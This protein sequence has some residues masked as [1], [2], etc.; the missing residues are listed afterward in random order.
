[1]TRLALFLISAWL[2]L[3]PSPRAHAGDDPGVVFTLLLNRPQTQTLRVVMEIPQLT[4]TEAAVSMPAWRPGR[5]VI[6][7]PAS[8]VRTFAAF[9][10]HGTALPFRKSDKAT[11]TIQADGTAQSPVDLRIE[12]EIYANELNLRT[13]HVDATHAFLDASSVCMLYAPRRA[14]PVH[15]R[16]EAPQGWRVST[17]LEALDDR[18]FF[19]RDY[20][21]LVDSPL[22]VGMHDLLEFQVDGIPHEIAIWGRGN[23]D[24]E[25]LRRDFADIVRE[26]GAIFGSLPY[27]RYVF[28]LHVQ[29][30]IGGGTEHYN[31]T[32]MQTR[33][34]TFDSPDSYRGFLGLVSHEFFHTW[35]VKRF[36]PAGIS[37]YDYA[38]ENYT[39]SLWMA[40]GTT[41]YYDDLTL[42]RVG[43]IDLDEYMKRLGRTIDALRSRPG[44]EVQSLEE[45]SFDAWIKFNKSGP[46]RDNTTVSF[47]GKGALAS[48]VIDME[49]R[50]LT[51]NERSLDD[52]MRLM[53][54]QFPHGSDGYTPEDV[55]TIASAVAGTDLDPIFETCVRRAGPLPLEDALAHVGLEL[56]QKPIKGAWDDE[57]GRTPEA[58]R[59]YLGLKVAS[60][61]IGA[62]VRAVLEDGPAFDA[63]VI[64]DDEIVAINGSRVEGGTFEQIERSLQ[65]GQDAELA[66]FRRDELVHIRLKAGS[67]PNSTWAVRMV[68]EP[69]AA[70]IRAFEM[71]MDKPWPNDE[72]DKD[73]GLGG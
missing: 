52:V 68:K 70:Q 14:D 44:R 73:V 38:H 35:N 64:A 62:R 26:Q 22:E 34:S 9:D 8:E 17:G 19:A 36:R 13:R 65:P 12:Y 18:T 72:D 42:A 50:R 3:Q 30:G 57:L 39:R 55:V 7:D 46:D 67:K 60:G 66:L 31:S 4:S 43:L 5:Y 25:R 20:D 47:Y 23:W 61:N 2:V 59:A 63:G 71:W 1:M 54:E 45:S 51:G 49:I 69:T 15:I 53:F 56:Y 16:I 28:Q 11:W 27:V 41:S 24:P 58:E 48:L 6:L 37:P 40:E 29:P 33:P 32:I 10:A 21:I